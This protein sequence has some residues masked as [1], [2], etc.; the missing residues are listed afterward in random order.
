[1]LPGSEVAVQYKYRDDRFQHKND[2]PIVAGDVR[3]PL[4]PLPARP[5]L[6]PWGAPP[7]RLRPQDRAVGFTRDYTREKH[8]LGDTLCRIDLRLAGPGCIQNETF[9]TRR[10]SMWMQGAPWRKSATQ[11]SYNP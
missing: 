5:S 8:S 10:S 11:V 6:P 7:S 9:P 2:V 1:M 3:S 4:A